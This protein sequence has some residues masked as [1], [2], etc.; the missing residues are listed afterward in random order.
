MSKSILIPL[1][2]IL[3]LASCTGAATTVDKS[4]GSATTIYGV[5]LAHYL[6]VAKKEQLTLLA[7]PFP[8]H[9]DTSM[10]Q[11]RWKQIVGS[12]YTGIIKKRKRLLH[13]V[14]IKEV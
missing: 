3:I 5:I 8:L 13:Q 2:L 1:V 9:T 4:P 7:D 12:S 6:N 11:T 10:A 14:G